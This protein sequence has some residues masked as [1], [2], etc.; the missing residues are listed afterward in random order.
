[1]TGRPTDWTNLA[2]ILALKGHSPEDA[3]NLL[4][5][6]D[7]PVELI[8]FRKISGN[9]IRV[10][11]LLNI[12]KQGVAEA[13]SEK[14]HSIPGWLAICEAIATDPHPFINKIPDFDKQPTTTPDKAPL[15]KLFRSNGLYVT[16]WYSAPSANLNDKFD[17][18]LAQVFTAFLY[19]QILEEEGGIFESAK[20]EGLL[21]IR[22]LASPKYSKFLPGY[23]DK[24][25]PL[26]AYLNAL[27]NMADNPCNQ[28]LIVLIAYATENKDGVT[29]D[30]AIYSRTAVEIPLPTINIDPEQLAGTVCT[31]LLQMPRLSLKE[32]QSLIDSG[33]TEGEARSEVELM[34]NS[35]PGKQA[36]AGR[37]PAQHLR[38]MRQQN[39]HIAKQN[40]RLAYRWD[41]LG[42][43]D[44]SVCMAVLS[45]MLHGKI[46]PTGK[47]SALELVALIMTV[48]WTSST[49]EKVCKLKL[50]T[51]A[52]EH[53]A[54]A[55]GFVYRSDANCNWLMQPARPSSAQPLTAEQEQQAYTT[56][57]ILPLQTGLR[58]EEVIKMY[59]EAE[60]NHCENAKRLLFPRSGALYHKEMTAFIARINRRHNCRLTLG[61]LSDHMFDA[62]ANYPGVDLIASMLITGRQHYL[63]MNPLHY[64]LLPSSLLQNTYRNVC[65]ATAKQVA[66]ELDFN[67]ILLPLQPVDEKKG[68][69]D[70]DS[71]VGSR[72]C[73]KREVV[74]NLIRRLQ[75]NLELAN[76]SSWGLDKILELHNNMAL[77]TSL[78]FAFATGIRGIKDPLFTENQIDLKVGLAFLSDKDGADYYNSRIVWIPPVC[79]AQYTLYRR[80]LEHLNDRLIYLNRDL[81][82]RLQ[83]Y[84]GKSAQNSSAPQLFFFDK[85]F[86]DTILRPAITHKMLGEIFSLPINAN[87][88]YVRSNLITRG[89]PAVT[90][91]AF[92]GHWERGEEPSGRFSA[93][94]PLA[95]RQSLMEYLLPLLQEDGWKP[96]YGLGGKL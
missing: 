43:H 46:S 78:L 53:T 96:M 75:E 80:H 91:N 58:I 26:P 95:Y 74:Q 31:Q 68:F 10:L 23:P 86:S 73:P 36:M 32:E 25:V 83:G 45:E 35:F 47:L 77:Y 61:K 27:K 52:D 20:Y 44:V 8:S 70:S 2:E 69:Q 16:L 56:M 19:L 13:I 81:F 39:M 71:Y 79:V 76:Q 18:L 41:T 34:T 37:T 1:M 66:R 51:P 60:R 38:R 28:N 9:L 11:T 64:S 12:S 33:C 5:L 17:L 63:G 90:V 55:A 67:G 24:V 72:Y 29:R 89:C 21:S 14:L 65:I 22:N 50:Y 15:N 40:Q 59:V 88:H 3:F 54:T 93:L 49:L 62:I 82:E 85:Q 42:L 57:G 7:A 48:F 87:R 92:L 6:I 94:S 30:R 84:S 4:E